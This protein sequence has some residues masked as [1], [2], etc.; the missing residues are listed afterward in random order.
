MRKISNTAGALDAM[1]YSTASS[2]LDGAQKLGAVSQTGNLSQVAQRGATF[3]GMNDANKLVG[4]GQSM[5]NSNVVQELSNLAK[6]SPATSQRIQQALASND[7][8]QA[9]KIFAQNTTGTNISG[10]GGLGQFNLAVSP[11]RPDVSGNVSSALSISGGYT[12]NMGYVSSA[13]AYAL[14]GA[15]AARTLA[16]AESVSNAIGN[17]LNNFASVTP[18][19]KHIQN[20]KKI[21]SVF[22]NNRQNSNMVG[23][24]IPNNGGAGGSGIPTI[25]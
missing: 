5:D 11:N 7:K 10:F 1:R 6:L 4:L 17:A 14:G 25:P 15:D 16:G 24:N 13:A 23:N 22:Q 18:Y 9:Y 2:S 8:T 21:T 3:A 20:L 12:V 19:G